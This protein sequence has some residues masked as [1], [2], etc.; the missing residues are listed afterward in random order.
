MLPRFESA[1]DLWEYAIAFYIT[2]ET[3]RQRPSNVVAGFKELRNRVPRGNTPARRGLAFTG[4]A[5]WV[6]RELIEET[7][8]G[9]AKSERDNIR[10]TFFTE[11]NPPVGT[12]RDF[13]ASLLSQLREEGFGP[14]LLRK[15]GALD[16]FQQVIGKSPE[17]FSYRGCLLIG[18]DDDAVWLGVTDNLQLWQRSPAVR[19]AALRQPVDML[20]LPRSRAWLPSGVPPWLQVGDVRSDQALLAIQALL[21]SLHGKF[22]I[23]RTAVRER[24]LFDGVLAD[25]TG[26]FAI[27]TVAAHEELRLILAQSMKQSALQIEG[28]LLITDL[29][30]ALLE[31]EIHQFHVATKRVTRFWVMT[32]AGLRDC[33]VHQPWLWRAT[34]DALPQTLPL[35]SDPGGLDLV[36]FLCFLEVWREYDPAVE[37]KVLVRVAKDILNCDLASHVAAVRP[38][39]LPDKATDLRSAR[40]QAFFHLLPTDCPF[41]RLRDEIEDWIVVHRHA[42]DRWQ[43]MM[44]RIA[45]ANF[46]QDDA[47]GIR[48]RHQ[49]RLA[50]LEGLLDAFP[51]D[52]RAAEDAT[53]G[54]IAWGDVHFGLTHLSDLLRKRHQDTVRL[55]RQLADILAASCTMR[56]TERMMA[57]LHHPVLDEPANVPLIL[58]TMVQH[59]DDEVA[60]IYFLRALRDRNWH[61]PLE[62]AI[63]DLERRNPAAAQR[64]RVAVGDET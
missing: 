41:T 45:N 16:R 4:R 62:A 51:D 43:E 49:R 9:P 47:T 40:W 64:L 57:I 32:T 36:R 46:R 1:D 17:H 39:F 44:H 59:Q 23:V 55:Q 48:Q 63:S 37:L 22:R 38:A 34:R 6:G 10:K 19:A 7:F 56:D 12:L 5:L 15:A 60:A 58:E 28:M 8:G 25:A 31:D 53:F 20:A 18:W 13:V 52:D 11:A 21:Q 35:G 26:T 27:E 24:V 33:L 14:V 30:T 42:L 2:A 61:R 29:S 54:A 50:I 3:V